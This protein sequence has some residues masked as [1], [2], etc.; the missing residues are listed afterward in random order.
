MTLENKTL[1]F[2]GVA[3]AVDTMICTFISII[4]LEFLELLI[5]LSSYKFSI[6]LGM[7]LLIFRDV[8]GKSLGKLL[9]GLEIVDIKSNKK[10][11]LY[12]R[13]L[14]NITAPLTVIEGPIALLRKDKKRLG[15][16]VA[17]TET[18]I[19]NNSYALTLF[20]HFIK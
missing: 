13:L 9:L 15:D 2:R 20:N 10:A 19:N 7:L 18:K 14:K 16:I 17:K 12:Q 11:K 5:T 6:A 4:C 8:F 1:L 3:F